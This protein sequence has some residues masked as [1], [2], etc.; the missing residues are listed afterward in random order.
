MK[1]TF[2]NDEQKEA[3]TDCEQCNREGCV[4]RGAFRRHDEKFGG[5]GECYN[6]VSGNKIASLRHEH[7][8]QG[9]DEAVA[10]LDSRFYSASRTL[11]YQWN[12]ILPLRECGHYE[13]LQEPY[14]VNDPHKG[15]CT[16]CSLDGVKNN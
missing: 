11:Q 6:L 15:I 1:Y 10:Y 4:H 5:T 14:P 9:N 8:S 16:R 13:L 7:F 12:Y 2:L 3:L